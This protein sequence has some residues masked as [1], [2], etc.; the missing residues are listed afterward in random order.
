LRA[1]QDLAERMLRGADAFS[2]QVQRF[3]HMHF[4]LVQVSL[5][6]TSMQS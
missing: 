2:D 5:T 1:I 6:G 4:P 3:S